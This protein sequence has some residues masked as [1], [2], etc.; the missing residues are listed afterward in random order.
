MWSNH[1]QNIVIILCNPAIITTSIILTWLS[2]PLLFL[3]FRHHHQPLSCCS[4]AGLAWL[5]WPLTH[6]IMWFKKVY[7]WKSSYVDN[8]SSA[9]HV[10]WWKYAKCLCFYLFILVYGSHEHCFILWACSTRVPIF[11][12]SYLSTTSKCKNKIKI[13]VAPWWLSYWREVWL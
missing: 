9:L 11:I 1:V 3:L 12:S 7:K 8:D 13:K 10:I 5:P 4:S 2:F 6:D